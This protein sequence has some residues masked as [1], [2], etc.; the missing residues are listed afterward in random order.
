MEERLDEPSSKTKD[1]KFCNGTGKETVIY[2][3]CG[4]NITNSDIMICPTCKEHCDGAEA[5]TCMACDGQGIVSAY[6]DFG[7]KADRIYESKNDK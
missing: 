1:C 2:S 3:C 5:D 7:A 4:D 6:E